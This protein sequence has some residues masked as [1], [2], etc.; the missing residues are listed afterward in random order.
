MLLGPLAIKGNVAR[1]DLLDIAKYRIT[2]SGCLS[3][4]NLRNLF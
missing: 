4:T 3:H 1:Y 2:K